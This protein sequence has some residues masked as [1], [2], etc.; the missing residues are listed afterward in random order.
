MQN[1]LKEISN[2]EKYKKLQHLFDK[3]RCNDPKLVGYVVDLCKSYETR[4]FNEW[5]LHYLELH[6]KDLEESVSR[7]EETSGASHK[8]CFLCIITFLIYKT[9]VGVAMERIA[10]ELLYGTT[11]V[12]RDASGKADNQYAVDLIIT[13]NEKPLYGIQIKPSTYKGSQTNERKNAKYKET[14]GY[15]VKYLYYSEDMRFDIK[16][17]EEIKDAIREAISQL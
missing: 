17:V 3:S 5:F 12:V 8:D 14:F 16:K 15:D 6:S 9:W 11:W 7:L 2:S 4:N 13:V 10:K 1:Q